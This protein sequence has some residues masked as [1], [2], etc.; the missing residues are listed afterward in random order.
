MRHVPALLVAVVLVAI[1]AGD[2]VSRTLTVPPGANLQDALNRARP[3]D[4]ILLARS[5]TY[6]GN[7]VLPANEGGGGVITLRTSGDEGFPA[8][9]ERMLP[10]AAGALAKVRSPNGS[11]ALSTAPGARGWRVAL[12]EFS[13]NRDGAGD[14]IALGDG[15][16]AQNTLASVPQ[17]LALDRL[18]IHGDE[19][20]GQ[21]R[22]IALNAGDTTITGCFI[23]DIKAIGQDS[24]A[25]GGWN[26]P[27]PYTIENNYLEAAG[28]NVMFGGGD[29]SIPDLTPS[30][31]VVRRNVLSKPLAWRAPG[32]PV[33]QVKNLFELKNARG[34]L[35]ERNVMERSWQQAQ[36][37]YAVLFTVRNQDGGC[38]WC[39]VE[40][41]EFRGNVVR[42][43]AAGIVVLGTDPNHP[44]RQTSNIR[45]HDN[46][47]DGIDRTAWGG[48]GYFMLLSDGPRDVVVDHNTI[49]QRASGGVIRIA[50]GVARGIVF[51]NNVARHGRY[52]IVGTNHT[53]GADTIAAY[54]PGATIANNVLAG[55][56]RSVYPAGNLFPSDDEF[57]RQFVAF[58]DGNFRLAPAS[59]WRG[60]GSDRRDLGAD[61][62]RVA[63]PPR[64]GSNQELRS[65]N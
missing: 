23:S 32:G 24:Q 22:A 55:G 9:D 4:T 39:Q 44:S 46:L 26:G 43:V 33:W 63:E 2:P 27:G 64:R 41:V 30:R 51:T 37:G 18:Y 13:A 38:P 62:S 42:D 65:K 52:G 60:A 53:S 1:A 16:G 36:S 25:V 57:R 20:K 28:E 54:L 12:L 49:V 11:P 47:F 61:L 17:G 5:A 21:K 48:D 7:F 14:I 15:G 10:S 6:V 56:N 58:D 34:V 59:H 19:D 8:D 29:P 31:I 45:I 3:G 40:D 50:H 35:V